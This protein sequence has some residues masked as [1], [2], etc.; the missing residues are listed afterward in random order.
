MNKARRLRG[1]LHIVLPLLLTA[2]V[3]GVWDLVVRVFTI[4]SYVLPSPGAVF[5]Q[6]GTDWD[7]L[8]PAM[9]QTIEEFVI[10]FVV[11]VACGFVLAVAMGHSR[12]EERRV[13]KECRL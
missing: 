4:Q 9:W 3:F 10:G 11:G 1:S 7:V 2:G 5:S 13:G 6:I 12:S 8:Q